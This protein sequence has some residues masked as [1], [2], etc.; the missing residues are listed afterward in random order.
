[1]SFID[2]WR[3]RLRLLI[4]PREY[5]RDLADE[6]AFHVER[7]T[8]QQSHN[9]RGTIN[10]RDAQSAARRQVGNITR[11]VEETRRVA[12]LAAFDVFGQ[13]VRFALRSFRRTPSFTIIVVATL[14][15]GIGATTAIFSAVDA[16]LLRPL[17]FANPSRLMAVSLSVPGAPGR[18]A[19]DDQRLSYPK[20]QAFKRAQHLFSDVTL[21][22][23]S[24]FTLRYGNNTQRTSGEYVDSR[25]FP[26]LGI[27]L[28]LGRDFLADEDRQLGGPRVLILGNAMW[29]NTLGGDSSIVGR[30]VQ[31]DGDA[32]TVVG[33]AAPEFRGV[34]GTAN[35]WMPLTSAPITRDFG[36]PYNHSFFIVGRLAPDISIEHARAAMPQIG[37]Q[38]DAAYPARRANEGHWSAVARELDAARA[39][40][41]VQ[42]TLFILLGAVLLMLLTACANV[43][44]LLLVRASARQR[45]V[46]VRLALGATRVRLA[47]QLL[48]E[49]LVLAI[50]G[51]MASIVVGMLSVKLLASVETNVLGS[52]HGATGMGTAYFSTIQF[53][54]SALLFTG[55]IAFATGL[56]FGLAPALHATRTSLLAATKDTS[57][58]IAIGMRRFTMR[59]ALTLAE[60]TFAVV[61]L[62]GSGLM[63]RSINRLLDVRA[64]FDASNLLTFRINRAPEWARDSIDRFYMGA[65]DR[66]AA[67]PGVR[68]VAVADCPPLTRCADFGFSRLDRP[69]ESP[70]QM[71]YTGVHWISPD[72]PSVMGV[73]LVRGRA[74]TTSD[75]LSARRVVLINEMAAK[76]MW[77]NEDPID[78]AMVVTGGEDFSKDTLYVAGV[79]ADVLFDTMDSR[80]VPEVFVPYYQTH[81]TYRMMFFVKTQVDPMQS[82]A[83][84]VKE[85]QKFAPGF[86]VYEMQSQQSRVDETTAYVRVTTNILTAFALVALLLAMIGTYGVVAFSVSQRT[87]EI[88]VRV[89]LGATSADISQLVMGHAVTLATVGL[90]VGLGVALI[91]TRALQSLLYEVTPSDPMTLVGIV[92]LLT[93]S[94]FAA[95]WIPARKALRVMPASILRAQ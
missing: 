14:A 48:A 36:V 6:L 59:H 84:V 85:L 41:I 81:F 90:G 92:V 18:P 20:F 21:W 70:E 47:R 78:R 13:D 43:A 5:D 95:T 72:W 2:G 51:G 67:L 10:E 39:A 16:L 46:A 27:P 3:H 9:A 50:A 65:I 24:Q 66:L 44:N 4:K 45:E 61:L 40:P 17:P 8:A 53:D 34:S 86:P 22:T 49:S 19:Y 54:F 31:V 87:R 62:V 15:I 38:I 63:I 77:P 93:I 26:T 7:E 79:I 33:V 76:Q 11:A 68:G 28:A 25:Y 73:P 56:V 80:V 75:N 1:M 23:V 82:V 91:A 94:V 35:F 57:Q 42:R 32:Y 83:R 71:M 74:F 89:A 88:A 30:I 37:A 64:G 52:T 69:H 29:R 58:N 12:G 60:I 55:S